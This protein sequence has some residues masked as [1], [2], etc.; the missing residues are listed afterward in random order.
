MEHPPPGSWSPGEY[1]TH[2]EGAGGVSEGGSVE[3]G[4]Q[5]GKSISLRYCFP[6]TPAW[7]CQK[8]NI[9]GEFTSQIEFRAPQTPPFWN[10]PLGLWSTG[11]F[12]TPPEGARGVPEGGSAELGIQFGTFISLRYCFSATPAWGCQ[13]SN[14]AG[15]Y[16]S[17][18]GFRTPQIPQFWNPPS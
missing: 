15:K 4:I 9:A 14:I 12:F 2:P 17:Q 1:L 6:A 7:G 10:P 5:F 16:T 13:K 8:S 18:I 11:E 3:L